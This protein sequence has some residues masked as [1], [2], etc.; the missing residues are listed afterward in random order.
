MMWI[1]IAVLVI[2]GISSLIRCSWILARATIFLSLFH[3]LLYLIVSLLCTVEVSYLLKTYEI[4]SY[5][6]S[7]FDKYKDSFYYE[8]LV[9][10][11]NNDICSKARDVNIAY[12]EMSS[13]KT[14]AQC[15]ILSLM[16][17]T[18]TSYIRVSEKAWNSYNEFQKEEVIYHELGHCAL[19][20]GHDD[21]MIKSTL[22]PI[23]I[24]FP[25]SIMYPYILNDF[26]YKFLKKYYMV[27]LFLPYIGEK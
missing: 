14:I 6:N 19:E 15:S 17:F 16:G 5:K 4:S 2:I 26:D 24:E 7:L 27:E 18:L 9:I 11:K 23:E 13:D 1:L 12:G 20:R 22:G 21:T 10:T 3:S 8:C 25:K